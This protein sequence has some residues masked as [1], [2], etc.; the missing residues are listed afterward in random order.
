MKIQPSLE[1]VNA[2]GSLDFE[3]EDTASN[4]ETRLFSSLSPVNRISA[5]AA[6][7]SPQIEMKNEAISLALISGDF[8]A[9]LLRNV[10]ESRSLVGGLP[11]LQLAAQ[12]A[13]LFEIAVYFGLVQMVVGKRPEDFR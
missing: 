13:L 7:A 5:P 6:L 9:R 10:V 4:S 1:R 12:G 3:T 11:T 2:N 8:Q